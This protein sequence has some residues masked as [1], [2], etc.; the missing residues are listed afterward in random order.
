[1][2]Y[3]YSISFRKQFDISGYEEN[4]V[5]EMTDR[6]LSD[7][8]QICHEKERIEAELAK[9]IY[10][11]FNGGEPL[12]RLKQL[13]VAILTLMSDEPGHL[14]AFD[15]AVAEEGN[16]RLW[17]K[18]QR[19]KSAFKLFISSPLYIKRLDATDVAD[20]IRLSGAW[21]EKGGGQAAKYKESYRSGV[22]AGDRNVWH[23][24]KKL[25]GNAIAGLKKDGLPAAQNERGARWRHEGWQ[26]E[27]QLQEFMRDPAGFSGMGGAKDKKTGRWEHSKRLVS[28]SNLSIINRLFGLS[29]GCDISGTTCDQLYAMDRW[30]SRIL[31]HPAYAMLPLG[32]IVHNCHHTL[33][34]VALALSINDRIAYRMGFFDTLVPRQGLPAELNAINGT[35]EQANSLM[36]GK[37]LLRYYAKQRPAGCFRFEQNEIQRLRRADIFHAESLLQLASTGRISVFPGRKEVLSLIERY[38]K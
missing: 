27:P 37:H 8:F 6:Q 23:Q 12:R 32:V 38:F 36:R 5:E 13:G 24:P 1:L 17:E 14:K 20:L 25:F 4:K 30:G 33:L 10:N 31:G 22:G 21:V 26:V 19:S 18:V 28:G 11:V 9:N 2:F 3:L 7:M 16:L 29:W 35:I 34:E 15:A